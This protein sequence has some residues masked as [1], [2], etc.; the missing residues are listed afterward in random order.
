MFFKL[1]DNGIN[2]NDKFKE[3]KLSKCFAFPYSLLMF[4]FYDLGTFSQLQRVCILYVSFEHGI[5][6]HI[7]VQLN[8]EYHV[9]KVVFS[10]SCGY[11]WS[12]WLWN[13]V[14]LFLFNV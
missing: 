14:S 6:L 5:A 2:D 9:E 12:C 4:G 10:Y 7:C 3:I 1:E 8:L 11:L 13:S